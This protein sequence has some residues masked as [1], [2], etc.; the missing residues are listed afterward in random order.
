MLCLNRL[1]SCARFKR[2]RASRAGRANLPGSTRERDLLNS[3]SRM[4]PELL[5][6]SDRAD[7]RELI[8][9]ELKAAHRPAVVHR[10]DALEGEDE[11]PRTKAPRLPVATDLWADTEL[12]AFHAAHGAGGLDAFGFEDD[13]MDEA[14][15]DGAG[16]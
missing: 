16:I 7:V 3:F 4:L 12:P 9:D 8:S 2:A 6:H 1:R 5:R 13:G 10:D 15:L 14:L 11:A